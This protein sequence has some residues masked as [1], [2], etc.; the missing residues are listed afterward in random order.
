MAR[1]KK[2]LPFVV[3]PKFEPIIE[4]IGSDES[5]KF[6]I[7]RKGYL[8]VAEKA[9]VQGSSSEDGPMRK[10]IDRLRVIAE[11]AGV[12]LERVFSDISAGTSPE[13]LKG[14]ETDL[15][16]V[17]ELFQQ[18]EDRQKLVTATAL[19]MTRLDADWK[20]EDTIKLHPDIINDLYRLY[21][22]EDSR[23]VD[24]M[25]TTLDSRAEETEQELLEGK[26]QAKTE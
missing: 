3:E 5:G 22:E 13:Y 24:A 17:T 14:H 10:A 26:D 12:P 6:E 4:L 15:L 7:Q 23:C 8:T 16:L 25:R 1:K 18:H 2:G 21:N 20:A 9:I 19:I 11:K